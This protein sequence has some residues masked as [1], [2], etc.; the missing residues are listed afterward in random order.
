MSYLGSA[1]LHGLRSSLQEPTA[2]SASLRQSAVSVRDVSRSSVDPLGRMSDVGLDFGQPP[3]TLKRL[4]MST[5]HLNRKKQLAL[6]DKEVDVKKD[7]NV[8]S[9]ENGKLLTP[10]HLAKLA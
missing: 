10:S 3:A 2:M 9:C 4:S 7:E 6:S 1:S 5:S 8:K